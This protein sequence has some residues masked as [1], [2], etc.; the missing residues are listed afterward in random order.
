MLNAIL[1]PRLTQFVYSDNPQAVA[2]IFE[3][4]HVLL[5]STQKPAS[6]WYMRLSS[7][8]NQHT[9]CNSNSRTCPVMGPQIPAGARPNFWLD[10]DLLEN[11]YRH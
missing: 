3:K 8:A 2:D 4:G 9:P 5:P 11:V 10:H 1:E 6:N 7:S